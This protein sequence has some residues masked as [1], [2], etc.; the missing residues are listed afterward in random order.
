HV[1]DH[2]K[3]LLVEGASDIEHDFFSQ[4]KLSPV[5]TVFKYTQFEE[6]YKILERLTNH[7]GTGHSCGIHTFNQSYI[8]TLGSRMKTSRVMVNQPQAAGNGG[9]FFNG[10]PSTVSL[11]CGSWG[12]NITSENITFKHFINVTWV[13]EYFTPKRPTDDEIFGAYLAEVKA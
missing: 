9:A 4:E 2:V 13:S 5:L 8:E 6:G 10:M 12:G 3:V 11:G 1:D 7:Y